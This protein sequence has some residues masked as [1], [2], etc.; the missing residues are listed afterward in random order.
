MLYNP[1]Y[2]PMIDE[3][4]EKEEKN[5]NDKCSCLKGITLKDIGAACII[6]FIIIFVVAA[7]VSFVLLPAYVEGTNFFREKARE[8]WDREY[9]CNEALKNLNSDFKV[10]T[11]QYQTCL[12]I[13][14]A[15]KN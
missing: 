6:G 5:N 9:K 12:Q 8:G 2:E 10:L 11:G 14:N 3:E 13:M 4:E 15:T 7:I 1:A